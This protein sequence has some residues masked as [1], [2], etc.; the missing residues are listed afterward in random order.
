MKKQ[1]ASPNKINQEGNSE[2][3]PEIFAVEKDGK[4]NKFN[5]RDFIKIAAVTATAVAV[6]GV[7]AGCAPAAAAPAATPT[8]QPTVPP[9]PT[10]TTV[11]TDTPTMTSSPTKTLVPT[12]TPTPIP[13]AVAKST[14]N[15]RYG[16]NSNA[17]LIGTIAAGDR[18][19]VIGKSSDNAWFCI[20]KPGGAIGWVSASLVDLADVQL[21]SIPFVTPMPTPTELPGRVGV[22]A[23]GQT[24]INYS[25]TNSY[26]TEYSY[27]LPCGS[28]IPADAVC[29]CNCV[30]APCSCD[31]YVACSCD[32][33]VASC[34]CDGAS[35]Y[36]YPN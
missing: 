10:N 30:T 24:G 21:D 12:D 20:Q 26:G 28:D 25:Y 16:P 4:T 2:E 13:M 5:R 9:I 14:A 32:G 19:M 33:Y 6:M 1:T 22:V 35:H 31:S 15:V 3:M 18:V 34:G 36:W 29:V 27:T 11:P 23:P 7:D 17:G 8:K